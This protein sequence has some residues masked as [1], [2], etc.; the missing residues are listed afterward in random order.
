[1][2][3]SK[4]EEFILKACKENWLQMNP[5]EKARF[6]KLCQKNI[7]DYSEEEVSNSE[8][9]VCLRQLNSSKK[10]IENKITKKIINFLTPKK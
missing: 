8:Q 3:P 5:S 9:I 4:Q 6:C 1:M 10:D 2:K 7:F